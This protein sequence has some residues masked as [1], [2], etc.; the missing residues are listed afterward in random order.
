MDQAHALELAIRSE[1]RADL[2]ADGIPHPIKNVLDNH[3]GTLVF[4]IEPAALHAEEWVLWLPEE[5]A[6]AVQILVAL[7]TVDP[8]RDPAADRWRIYHGSPTHHHWAGARALSIRLGSIVA[9]AETID[10]TNP[11]AHAEPALCKAH[12]SDRP[13]LGRAA[14]A[15]DPRSEGEGLM[16]GVD[17]LGFDLRTRF[18]VVRIPFGERVTDADK[19]RRRTEELLTELGGPA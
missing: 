6:S 5:R 15:M 1:R 7:E 10:L 14:H 2:L 19:A 11:L 13:R 3:A 12:N 16:V 8:E 4:P 18:D 17:P 9:G